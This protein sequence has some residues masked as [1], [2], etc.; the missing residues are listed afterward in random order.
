MLN[1]KNEITRFAPGRVNL[2][3]EHTDYN[4]GYVFPCTVNMG[5]HCSAGRRND[6]KLRL[7]SEN[8]PQDGEREYD[9]DD[10]VM[11]G[12]WSDYPV[13]VIKALA[14]F[15]YRLESGA[16]ML[17]SGDLPYGAGLSSSAAI[18]VLTGAVLRELFGLPLTDQLIAIAGQFAENRFIGV[19]CGIMDQ[20]ASI[21][22]REG[23][24]VLLN[25][26]T[27]EYEY[28]PLNGAGI[29]VVNSGVRHSLASS[30]YN[31]RRQECEAAA[32]MLNVTSLCSLSPDEFEAR[33]H[34]IT[35]PVCLKRARHA[36]YENQR[37]IA[38]AGMLRQGDLKSFGRLMNESH[39]SLRDDYEVSCAETDLL[40]QA[41]QSVSGVY[42]ARMTGGGF[43]GCTV[44]LIEPSAVPEFT[45]AVSKAYY[46]R[47]NR[48]PSFYRCSACL[49]A[50]K[51]CV[52]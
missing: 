12:C 33:K 49:G 6:R 30:E 27:L 40:V 48:L 10:P 3:G 45:S 46:E 25:S 42:G 8:F 37:T 31:R 4:G 52:K 38:A 16:D 26:H 34:L 51:F 17:F 7:Y 44:N 5:I 39:A 35:D 2:I 41:A 21:M 22:G 43:G 18:E 14:A 36:V 47:F 19:N 11:Q 23:C 24:A 29:V 20:F 1:F 28:V 50:F 9:L 32:G 13:S 15:G